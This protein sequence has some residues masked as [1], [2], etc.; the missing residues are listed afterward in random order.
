MFDL[1]LE[2]VKKIFDCQY[3]PQRKSGYCQKFTGS[4]IFMPIGLHEGEIFLKFQ[5][6]FRPKTGCKILGKPE[7]VLAG[8]A[9]GCSFSAFQGHLA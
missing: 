2:E 9:S 1:E 7:V 6:K 8:V 5:K 3:L 4:Q